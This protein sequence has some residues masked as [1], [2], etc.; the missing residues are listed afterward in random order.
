MTQSE[1]LTILKTGANAFL[2]GEPGSGKTHTVNAYVE[3]LRTHGI[4]PAVTASTGIAATHVGGMTIHAWSGIGIAKSLSPYDLDRIASNERVAKR[5]RHAY[6]LIIDEISMLSADTLSMAEEVC[7][8]VR[9]P[10]RPFGGLQVVFV[11]DF[12][13]LPPVS[14]ES[15]RAG[16]AFA[17][18]A[19]EAANP[20]VCY[21][22]EQHRQ[23]DEAFLSILSAIRKGE[24]TSEHR[25]TLAG[26]RVDGDIVMDDDALAEVTRLYTHNASV[27]RMNDA[28]LAALPGR[29]ERYLMIAKGPEHLTDALKRGCLSPEVLTL[30]EGARVMFT[31]NDP[32]GRY[33]NGTLG[34]VV[35]FE[36]GSRYPVVELLNNEEIIVAPTEWKMDDAGKT[37]ATITQVP[38]RLAWAMT[39]HKSQGLSLD[40]ATVDLSAAFEY[41]QG[42]VA[43]SR[44][45][46]L[47]GL[48]LYG[49]NDR[50]LLV[51]PDIKRKDEGFRSDSGAA[52]AAF[53]GL[54]EGELEKMARNFI[55]ASGG[56]EDVTLAARRRAEKSAPKVPTVEIT[57]GLL[58]EGKSLAEMAE[59]RGVKS[60]TI[61]D[62]LEQLTESGRIERKDIEHLRDE[63]ERCEDIQKAFKKLRTRAMKPVHAHFRG[64]V[65]YADIRLARLLLFK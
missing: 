24:V 26:R 9:N 62:H 54:G 16:F 13:Q 52:R 45:R 15:A 23:E 40:A 30:K 55:R 34:T 59:E 46:T 43:L 21:L 29:S 60:E 37:L 33:A 14:K 25:E 2:T 20:I 27:D 38:L 64:D 7:R 58:E 19:W 5:I 3:W 65:S 42:Y 57:L 6:V 41:G 39:V 61:I 36:S 18:P 31:K 22:D 51:H 63:C 32:A 56:T 1:A 8:T 28:A 44:V 35:G 4:E 47:E 11:G 50:A 49:M 53:G 12:F 10:E 48:S 17:S